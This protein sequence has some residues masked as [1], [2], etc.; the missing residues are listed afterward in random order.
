MTGAIKNDQADAKIRL[1]LYPTTALMGISAVFTYG[2]EKYDD[3][4]WAKGLQYSRLYGAALRHLSLWYAGQDRDPET[5]MSHLWHAGCNLAM[6]IHTEAIVQDALN[7]YVL[8][9][10]PKRFNQDDVLERISTT[11]K[12]NDAYKQIKQ[13]KQ[14]TV[15]LDEAL[16]PEDYKE[17]KQTPVIP[18]SH[19]TNVGGHHEGA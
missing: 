4:N 8:D 10:R 12:N 17:P 6:L 2:A 14:P 5:N 19:I 15:S 18:L 16:H 3:W 13:R 11:L 1:D 9:D 7:E